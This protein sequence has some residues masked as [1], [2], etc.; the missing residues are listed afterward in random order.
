MPRRHPQETTEGPGRSKQNPAK[1][2]R[3][4]L[5]QAL[6]VST[7]AEQANQ[8]QQEDSEAGAGSSSSGNPMDVLLSDATTRFV[9]MFEFGAN[10]MC[11]RFKISFV[12]STYCK[13]G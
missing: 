2:K 5:W 4:P 10:P 3:N 9:N 8:Q 7:L 1:F 13:A 11:N 6:F 12:L